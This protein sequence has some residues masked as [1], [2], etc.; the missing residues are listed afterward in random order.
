MGVGAGSPKTGEVRVSFYL[1]I[2]SLF[3]S[4]N[5]LRILKKI[6]V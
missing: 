5:I 6:T 2:I 4:S 3:S 1:E